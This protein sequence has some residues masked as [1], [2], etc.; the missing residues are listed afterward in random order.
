MLII[1]DDAL[2]WYGDN[3]TEAQRDAIIKAVLEKL[4]KAHDKF[5]EIVADYDSTGTLP[6]KLENAINSVS[7]LGMLITMYSKQIDSMVDRYLGSGL[8]RHFESSDIME[9]KKF[10]TAVD[11]MLG[12]DDPVFTVDMLYDIF[13]RYDDKMQEKLKQLVDSGK[14]RK[15]LD[16]FEKMDIAKLFD[17]VGNSK[18]TSLAEKLNELKNKGRVTSAF[19]SM[20][21]TLVFIADHGIEPFR[22][23]ET[24]VTTQDAYE[25]KIGSTALKVRH[26]YE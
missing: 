2:C 24:V 7:Q 5:N 15:A 17:G 21:D 9:N 14:L 6:G 1:A 26:Y 18:V 16:K 12:T 25:V 8:N 22:I 10:Q 4:I 11:I 23:E 13:Y 19:E 3:L 20:Y